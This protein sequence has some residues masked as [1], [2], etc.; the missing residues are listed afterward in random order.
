MRVRL[1]RT[2]MALLGSSVLVYG[3]AQ[4]AAHASRTV[5]PAQSAPARTNPD[6]Q[7]LVDFKTRIDEYMALRNKLKK[8]AP[9]L[10]E[11]SDAGKIKASRDVLAMKVREARKTA[12]RGDI[13]TPG[14]QQLFRRLMYPEVKGKE[15]AETKAAIVEESDELK[16]VSLKVNAAYPDDAP[17][18]TVPPNILAALPKLPEDLEYRFVS[19]TMI[20]LDTHANLIVDFVPNAIQ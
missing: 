1:S 14:I 15:G 19:R 9:P 12:K 20:L 10:K 5:D 18:M 13:F 4:D 16:T 2:V 8:E 6:A 11:T 7:L 3:C 17:L